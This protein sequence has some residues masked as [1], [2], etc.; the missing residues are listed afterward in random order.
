VAYASID[1]QDFVV[2][3]TIEFLVSDESAD[4]P[5]PLALSKL[6]R[7][8]LAEKKNLIANIQNEHVDEVME[9]DM[10]VEMEDEEDEEEVPEQ[11]PALVSPSLQQTQ[12]PEPAP[13]SA[14]IVIDETEPSTSEVPSSTVPSA[15]S[16]PSA[17]VE[18]S[19]EPTRRCPRCGMDI[20]V[21]EI[22]EHQKL[23]DE[24]G[25]TAPSPPTLL[26]STTTAS[27]PVPQSAPS[28]VSTP[29]PPHMV[30]TFHYFLCIFFSSFFT[31]L[32]VL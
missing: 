17:I 32:F 19:D 11:E 4:L 27:T 18:K 13:A 12:I 30:Y 15:L 6:S 10:E 26:P 1:W 23:E 8:S 5:P 22:E 25:V 3:E 7:M 2:V 31:L 9:G 20:P 21:S 28:S 29:Q 16:A 24:K 14:A